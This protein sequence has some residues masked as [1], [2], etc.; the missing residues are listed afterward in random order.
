MSSSLKSLILCT[1]FTFTSVNRQF[2]KVNMD[3]D[4]LEPN[5]GFDADDEVAGLTEEIDNSKVQIS[6]QQRNGRKCITLGKLEENG[7]FLDDLNDCK[8]HL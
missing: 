3:M 6:V 7:Q 2:Q 8:I 4:I 5:L 1:Q